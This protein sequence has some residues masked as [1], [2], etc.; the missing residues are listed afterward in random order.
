MND[1]LR[2]TLIALAVIIVIFLLSVGGLMLGGVIAIP[3][4]DLDREI[5]QEADGTV[6]GVIS[7]L[8]GMVE[9]WN[10]LEET[11][12][13]NEDNASLIASSKAQQKFLVNQMEDQAARISEDRVPASV[14]RILDRED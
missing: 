6:E 4:Q 1:G 11:I 12:L 5:R 8:Q 2:V 10:E 13:K 7:L 3:W 14:K 9:N